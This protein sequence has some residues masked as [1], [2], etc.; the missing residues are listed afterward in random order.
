MKNTAQLSMP[1]AM[2]IAHPHALVSGSL[3]MGMDT[4]RVLLVPPGARLEDPDVTC[5]PM[6]ENVWESGYSLVIDELKRGLLQDF[7]KY[8]YG[9]SAEMAVSGVQLM[10]FRKDIMAVTP[11]CVGEPAVLRFLVE[12]ARMCVRA[13]RQQGSLQVIAE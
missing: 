10:E 11:E 5:L 9:S 1:H 2:T 12:L 7:W 13:Y 8:Y 3:S 4:R 6:D